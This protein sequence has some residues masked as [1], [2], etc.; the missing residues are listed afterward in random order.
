[1]ESRR[2]NAGAPA[3]DHSP[4]PLLSPCRYP[5]A[6]VRHAVRQAGLRSGVMWSGV[7]GEDRRAGA[8]AIIGFRLLAGPRGSDEKTVVRF[9]EELG[10]FAG[11]NSLP[12]GAWRDSGAVVVVAGGEVR[13]TVLGLS[14]VREFGSS[15]G[16]CVVNPTCEQVLGQEFVNHHCGGADQAGAVG[17]W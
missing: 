13:G 4:S 10:A 17:Q 9:V 1:M 5:N 3:A 15:D 7:L 2:T 6:A 16:G 8:A 14:G 12:L 11:Q